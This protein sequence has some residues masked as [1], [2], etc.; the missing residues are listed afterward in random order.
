M[1]PSPPVERLTLPSLPPPPARAAF[2]IVA[3]VA[4]VVVSLGIWAFTG[5]PYSLLFAALGPVVALGGIVDGR[6]QRR[7]A[8]KADISAT[9]S[10]LQRLRE[11]ADRIHEQERRRRQA[12]VARLTDASSM[13]SRVG[14]ATEGPIPV[15]L[16]VADRE[17]VIELSAGEEPGQVA[18]VPELHDAFIALHDTVSRFGDA[19]WLVDGRD[20]IAVVGPPLL[21]RAVARSFLLQL[22]IQL[23][24]QLMSLRSSRD[25]SWTAALPLAVT[26]SDDRWFRLDSPSRPPLL[27]AWGS[28]TS[29]LPAGIGQTVVLRAHGSARYHAVSAARASDV[30]QELSRVADSLGLSTE[31]AALPTLVPLAELLSGD[32]GAEVVVTQSFGSLRAPLGRDADGIVEVDLVRD[33]PHAVVAGTTGTGKSELLVSWVVAMAARYPPSVVTF[34]LIDFKGGAAFSPLAGLPHVVG[35][36]S[37]LDARR[38]RRAIE[39]LRAELRWRETL[40]ADSGVRS[41]EELPASALARLVIVVDE[42]AAVVSG[43]PELHDVFADLAARGRSLGL[44]LVL[45]TQR[46]SGVIRDGILANVTLRISLRVI[47]RG[48]SLAMLGSEAASHLPSEPRGR[49]VIVDGSGAVRQVQLARA[50][51]S[52]AERV[53]L[54]TLEEGAITSRAIWCEPLPE[55]IPLEQL[56]RAARDEDASRERIPIG[57]MDLPAEQSQPI[58]WFDPRNDGHL[59]VLGAPRSGTTSALTLFARDPRSRVLPREP[60]DAWAVLHELASSTARRS[61]DDEPELLIIDDLDVLIDRF[62]PDVRHEFVERLGRCA[63]ESRQLCLVAGAQRLTPALQ[64]LAPLFESRILLRQSN[65]DEHVLAGGDGSRFDPRA[66]A[67]AGSWRGV[68]VQLAFES[69]LLPAPTI[70][71]VRRIGL[72]AGHGV[73]GAPLAIVA[74]RPRELD[75]ALDAAGDG[76][77]V[78]R[79]GEEQF[80]EPELRVWRGPSPLVLVGDPDA[81]QAEWSTLGWARRELT[82]VVID[83]TASE[84]RAIARTRDVPPPLSGQPGEC[85][86]VEAGEV[87]RAFLQL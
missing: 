23:P 61:P 40:L 32:S 14:A 16:G 76:L 9:L 75:A 6:R 56:T 85:W 78:V 84:L 65:R 68:P 79:L 83:C 54:T 58:A 26:W 30:A 53:R 11:R 55:L 48:D 12:D 31:H 25:E 81:W 45:C 60:A 17:P 69:T 24:P 37:D 19:P 5:S 29:E 15:L 52:D 33:G 62:D 51:R 36:V 71:P 35:I 80:D 67:G 4:P 47:D 74:G 87:R 8:M 42:F 82:L 41:I 10:A 46:P 66:P 50:D 64:R 49:A 7:R 73:V 43:E 38:S 86:L 27:V 70:P 21:A 2:P 13:W 3:T 63:R 1:L 59:L 34:L 18:V 57:R 77:R 44:H 28:E 22:M 39:S 20:G 72:T